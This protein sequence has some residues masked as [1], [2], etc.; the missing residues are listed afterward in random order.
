MKTIITV[1]VAILSLMAISNGAL[2]Q[3]EV[4]QDIGV[5]PMFD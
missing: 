3:F 4:R 1:L 5:S 2:A